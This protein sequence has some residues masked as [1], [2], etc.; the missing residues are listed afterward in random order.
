MKLHETTPRFYGGAWH[1]DE[2]VADSFVLYYVGRVI[3]ELFRRI[4]MWKW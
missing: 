3:A 1:N 2:N 4:I